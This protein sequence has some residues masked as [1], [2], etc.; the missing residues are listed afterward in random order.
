M[1]VVCVC[2]CFFFYLESP[3]ISNK[4]FYMPMK[5]AYLGATMFDWMEIIIISCYYHKTLQVHRT[6]ICMAIYRVLMH[7]C[8]YL[9]LVEMILLVLVNCKGLNMNTRGVSKYNSIL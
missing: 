6:D 5:N 9:W 7:Q 8:T 1:L 2:V 4:E 3:Y